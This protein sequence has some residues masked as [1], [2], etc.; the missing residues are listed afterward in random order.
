[1]FPR[2][3]SYPG[4]N[5]MVELSMTYHTEVVGSN[6]QRQAMFIERM[7]GLAEV[8]LELRLRPTGVAVVFSANRLTAVPIEVA[9]EARSARTP[10]NCRHVSG[11]IAGGSRSTPRGRGCSTTRTSCS[12]SARRQDA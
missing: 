8:I 11:A 5:P 2:Y 7:E 9:A 6:G 12:T 3:G 4:F 1:M 10:R